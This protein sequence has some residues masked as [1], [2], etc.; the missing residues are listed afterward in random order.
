[1]NK[2]IKLQIHN[3]I[4]AMI[5]LNNNINIYIKIVII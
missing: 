3:I 2:L 4:N 5:E 1:M